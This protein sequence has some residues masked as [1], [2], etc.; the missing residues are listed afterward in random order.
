MYTPAVYAFL[1]I[2]GVFILREYSNINSL[3]PI[4][5]LVAEADHVE[6]LADQ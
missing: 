4:E 2:A 3:K 6:S 1:T 5:E